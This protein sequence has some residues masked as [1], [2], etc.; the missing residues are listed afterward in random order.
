MSTLAIDINLNYTECKGGRGTC[1]PPHRLHIEN[2]TKEDF[3][4]RVDRLRIEKHV[5]DIYKGKSKPTEDL[6]S[7]AAEFYN[8]GFSSND[9][10]KVFAEAFFF[11]GSNF[12]TKESDFEEFSAKFDSSD[13]YIQEQ[14]ELMKRLVYQ[15]RII[16]S[17]SINDYVFIFLGNEVKINKINKI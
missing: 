8:R 7:K 16:R 6:A 12:E 11:I 3:E 15:E 9:E 5:V 14:L 10:M 4:A 2:M 1:K 13:E 17:V